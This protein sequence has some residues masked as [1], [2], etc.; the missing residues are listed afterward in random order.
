MNNETLCTLYYYFVYP[1]LN[2]C[3]KVRADTFKA[4]LQTLV[5]LQKKV[6]RIISYSTWC[7]SVDHL[8]KQ[9]GIMQLKKIHFFK[10]ALL[11][12]RVKKYV[13]TTCTHFFTE[14]RYVHDYNTR[15]NDKFHGPN[16]KRNYLQR[17][18][19]YKGVVIWNYISMYVTYDC[20]LASLTFALRNH[21]T[22]NDTLLDIF[23]L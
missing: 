12:F 17:T 23:L 10:V 15:Q 13:C 4:H 11:A 7:A 20:P 6:L 14:N 22:D 3:V 2:Y 5:K 8:Y 1:Y 19:I 21:V 9:Y 16:A 18:I